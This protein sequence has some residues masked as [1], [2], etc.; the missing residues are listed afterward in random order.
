MLTVGGV[1]EAARRHDDLPPVLF[2][3]SG[4][5]HTRGESADGALDEFLRGCRALGRTVAVDG[6]AD[7][8]AA[9]A[10]A[11]ELSRY[12][13][14]GLTGLRQVGALRG[15]Q[16]A[17]CRGLKAVIERGGG[18]WWAVSAASLSGLGALAGFFM[19]VRAGPAAGA[20][21]PPRISCRRDVA[22][23]V[24]SGASVA[25][26][27]AAFAGFALSSGR[28]PASAVAVASRLDH[29]LAANA[30]PLLLPVLL[31]DAVADVLECGAQ[32]PGS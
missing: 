22:P 2:V 6:R 31:E 9:V 4:P 30:R 13:T 16:P 32:M 23:A 19:V 10:A 1:L 14:A 12:A 17:D 15:V 7:D 18:Q 27:S 24:A 8:P 5:G 3:G 21:P 29:D 11:R 20:A 28:D 26:L 25:E